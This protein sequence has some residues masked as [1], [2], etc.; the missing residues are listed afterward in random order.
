MSDPRSIDEGDERGTASPPESA[1]TSGRRQRRLRLVGHPESMRERIVDAFAPGYEVSTAECL[2]AGIEAI[3][4]FDCVVT[5]A[6]LPDG[7]GVELLDRVR[8]TDADVPVVLFTSRTAPAL[9]QAFV[10]HNGTDVVYTDDVDAADVDP[11][12][13]G[14]D[15][16]DEPS[17]DVERL[18]RRVDAHCRQRVAE[19]ADTVLGVAG[20]LV[21][22]ARDELDTKIEWGLKSVGERLDASCALV[23]EY[24][25][26]SQQLVET[27]SWTPTGTLFGTATA[28]RPDQLPIDRFPGFERIQ[29]FDRVTY[30]ESSEQVST[31]DD[32]AEAAGQR[33]PSIDRSRYFERR[34]IGSLVAVPIV[35]D[36]KLHGV[37]VVGT[38]DRRPWPRSV[39][40]QLDTLGDLI[41]DTLHERHQRR[42][43]ET[44]NERLE[45]FASVISHDLQNPLNVISGYTEVVL[46]T[47]DVEPVSEIAAAADRMDRLLSDMLALTREGDDVGSVEPIELETVVTDAWEAVETTGADL[48]PSELGTIEADGSRLQQAIE[49]LFRNAIEH[50]IPDDVTTRE[51]S[52]PVL[53][54]RCETTADG[55]AIEDD[56]PGIP[57]AERERIFKEGYTG[58]N[59]TGLGLT[60]VETIVDA[61]GWSIDVTEGSDGGARFEIH[62]TGSSDSESV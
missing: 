50:G 5:A 8:D 2:E 21:G 11:S 7:D 45:R 48:S 9:V 42:E 46:R 55:F 14:G 40:Q 59:G 62:V 30:P 22:A 53:T 47:G 17:D 18:R 43:L 52:E 54:I 12:S 28:S 26:P 57:E 34:A 36:W 39:V 16:A 51:Q 27:H 31:D 61:H 29:A 15:E 1:Q 37:L 13:A 19:I 60:I 41:G 25:E 44:Q 32:F 20:T 6:D 3:E 23:Y 49:N 38:P 4:D 24:D 35:I 58:G 33:S 56:G 10:R